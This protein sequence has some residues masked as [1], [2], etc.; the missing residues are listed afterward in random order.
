MEPLDD[1]DVDRQPFEPDGNGD[2]QRA[3][4]FVVAALLLVLAGLTAFVL[5]RRSLQSEPQP[6]AGRKQPEAVDAR[7]PLGPPVESIELPTLDLT[8]PL[9]RTLLGRLSSRPEIAAWLASDGL[10]RNFVVSLDNVATGPSPARHLRRLAPEQPF[11][12]ESRDSGIV[13]DARSYERYNGIGDTVASLDASG[14][15]KIYSTLKPRLQEAHRELGHPE[16]DLDAAV[17]RAIERLLQVPVIETDV[18]VIVGGVSYEFEDE[19]LEA[20]SPAQK[21]LLR[22]GPRNVRLVQA[23]LREVAQAL[24]IPGARLP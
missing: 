16:S 9:V 1:Y 23:K 13:I 22:M 14:L 2:T 21:L 15:A 12:V 7:R 4:L 19:G 6:T 17:E 8:D 20:L 10:I 3:W 24:G 5:W 18:R 11:R